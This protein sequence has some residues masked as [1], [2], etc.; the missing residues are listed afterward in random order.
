MLK[1]E[2]SK[3]SLIFQ[4]FI[5]ILL[6]FVILDKI[7][8]QEIEEIKQVSAEAKY[9]LKI[10]SKLEIQEQINIIDIG[11]LT[12][13]ETKTFNPLTESLIFTVRGLKKRNVILNG[14][15]LDYPNK[16][17]ISKVNW[18]YW[19]GEQ[20]R[21]LAP[22]STYADSGLS[23]NFNFSRTLDEQGKLKIRI[24]PEKITASNDIK[25]GDIYDFVINVSCEYE[26]F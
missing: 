2:M 10:I 14:Q 25:P 23:D 6:Y 3:R 26:N 7:Y 5:L 4:A 22:Y 17:K 8:A 1:N 16:I 19:D 9:T 21:S 15:L 20:W 11:E 13:G 24:Y 18:E 12:P